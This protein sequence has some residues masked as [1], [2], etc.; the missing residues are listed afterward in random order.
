MANSGKV[1]K[2]LTYKTKSKL[3]FGI[4]VALLILIVGGYFVYISGIATKIIPAVRVEQTVDGATRTV[5]KAYVPELNYYRNQILS[6]Y[7]MYGFE[8]GEEYLNTIDEESGKTNGEVIYDNAAEQLASV[9]LVNEKAKKDAQFV[10]GSDRYAQAQIDL[11]ETRA[12]SNNFPS[13]NAYLAAIYGTGMSTSTFRDIVAAQEISQEYQ[14]YLKQFALAPT[15][16]ELQA[17]FDENTNG[18]ASVNF[19]G[20]L[21]SFEEFEGDKAKEA[22]EAVCKAAKD[23]DSFSQAVIDQIGADAAE[24]AGFTVESNSSYYSAVSKSSINGEAFPEGLEEFAFNQDNVGKAQVFEMKDK[25]WYVAYL[26]KLDDKTEPSYSYRA[27]VLENSVA[28]EEGAKA[29]KILLECDKLEKKAQQIQNGITDEYSFV[30]AVK[31]NT[32]DYDAITTGGYTKGVS[33]EQFQND[34]GL[35]VVGGTDQFGAWLTDPARQHGD[36]IIIRESDNS[37]VTLYYFDEAVPTWQV[38]AGDEITTSKLNDWSATAL[39]LS[40]TVPYVAYDLADKLT[41]YASVGN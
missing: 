24:A 29:D 22:A 23:S 21:F 35:E 9:M 31:E 10:T 1:S 34:S 5:G 13:I 40:N 11:M 15:Q 38:T 17:A 7:S 8:V 6:M 33:G 37:K 4:V 30:K 28:S 19:N 16:E 26:S 39:N 27:L 14:E 18:Y 41:Y 20:Y 36:M 12:S 3:I 2:G 32:D 25:G